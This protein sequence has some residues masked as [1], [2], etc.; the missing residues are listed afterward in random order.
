[1]KKT[2]LTHQKWID[3]ACLATPAVLGKYPDLAFGN[4][5]RS[6]FYSL[7]SVNPPDFYCRGIVHIVCANYFPF[8]FF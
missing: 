3:E 4:M 2:K 1:M 7:Y 6:L 5:V 8:V